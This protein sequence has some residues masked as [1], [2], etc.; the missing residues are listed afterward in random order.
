MEGGDTS[1]EGK[2]TCASW[3][4]RR[5]NAHLVVIG[6]S[7]GTCSSLDIFSFNSENT[8]LS[9]SPK[10]YVPVW[11]CV[12]ATF[13][14]ADPLLKRRLFELYK[15]EDNIKFVC[16][17]F[18]LQ[19]VGPQKCMAF[20]VD[21]S[22]LD[23]G[24]VDGHFRLFEWPTMCIIVDEPKAHK[25]YRDI[26]GI[27]S[28]TQIIV[29]HNPLLFIICENL[30]DVS[31][32]TYNLHLDSEFLASTSTDGAAR[33]WNTMGRC[34]SNF[35]TKCSNKTLIAGW[36]ISTW[37]KI[38]HKSLYNKPASI[39]TI[40]LDGKYLTLGG[41]DGDVCVVDVTRM[42]ISS[43][44]KRLYL[45]TIITS[46]EFCPSESVGLLAPHFS[47]VENINPGL[48]LFLFIYNNRE[49]YG[50]YEA[51]SSGKM[52]INPHGC[53]LDGFG[54]IEFSAQVQIRPRLDYNPLSGIL[55]KPIIQDNYNIDQHHF[56]FELDHVQAT[57]LISSSFL[58][59]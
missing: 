58:V 9:S 11:T 19:D 29:I 16:K 20:S 55:F 51:T 18:P 50:I 53:T 31:F 36:D 44:H 25:S 10:Y 12:F 42:E 13:N 48:L 7:A 6:K 45:G 21:G 39:M 43:L 28:F 22:K 35:V 52:N 41:K 24:T 59:Y 38:G 33:I 17:D 23:I 46:L 37:K 1:V 27:V 47:Y 14:C 49:L 8:S 30:P 32:G 56:M 26:S 54:R 57:N 5:E 2:V 4:K 34:S 40:S 3:I 15:H